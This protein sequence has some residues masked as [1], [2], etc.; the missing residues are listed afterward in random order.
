MTNIPPYHTLDPR[1]QRTF[2]LLYIAFTDLLKERHYQYIK[3][4]EITKAARI[5]RATF[6]NHFENKDE[7]IIFCAREGFR[8]GAVAHFSNIKL[9]YCKESLFKI[10]SWVLEFMSGE[11]SKW[12]YQW[13]EIL[14][15]KATRI[16]L[17]YFLSEWIKHPDQSDA[18]IASRDTCAMLV[19][20]SIVGLGMVW[21]SNGCV[22]PK[23]EL[24]VR[25]T[26][27]YA[28]GLPGINDRAER[29]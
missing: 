9:E 15:E 5:N 22:E 11:F 16:E 18:Q 24:S 26:D 25:I 14:F 13:D 17:Y 23:D 27:I 1:V 3:V 4:Q 28:S 6:Y 19:S 29:I 20:S 8:Q 21:C 2:D 10:V 7:F 12:H